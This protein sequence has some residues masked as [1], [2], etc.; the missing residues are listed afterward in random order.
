MVSW[1]GCWG[2]LGVGPGQQGTSGF[3]P[4]PLTPPPDKE[5][6]GGAKAP[7]RDEEWVKGPGKRRKLFCLDSEGEEASED[8]SSEKVGVP[9]P[10]LPPP[11]GGFEP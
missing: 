1:P 9:F 5:G 3:S 4:L 2:P 8:S 11:P 6:P 10:S 7:K